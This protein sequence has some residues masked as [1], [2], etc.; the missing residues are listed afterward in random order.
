MIIAWPTL[1]WP[2]IAMS[3]S[4]YFFL[5]FKWWCSMWHKVGTP[6]L[7]LL[8]RYVLSLFRATLLTVHSCLVAVITLLICCSCCGSQ[9]TWIKRMAILWGCNTLIRLPEGFLLTIPQQAFSSFTAPKGCVPA[10][11]CFNGATYCVI[12]KT[13]NGYTFICATKTF[14]LVWIFYDPGANTRYTWHTQAGCT[15]FL[16]CTDGPHWQKAWVAS[17]MDVFIVSMFWPGVCSS[18]FL[19]KRHIHCSW[20][21]PQDT[22]KSIYCANLSQQSFPYE[23]KD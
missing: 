13:A 3:S 18:P 5:W 21:C 23:Y 1:T 14:M 9:T 6:F 11:G 4:S 12:I 17:W 7:V 22:K 19:Y 20:T 10:V 2:Y 16:F 15:G 8:K